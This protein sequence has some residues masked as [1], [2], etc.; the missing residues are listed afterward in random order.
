MLIDDVTVPE[1]DLEI[2]VD[3]IADCEVI[4]LTPST[5]TDNCGGSVIVTNDVFLPINTQGNTIVICGCTTMETEMLPPNSK[6]ETI[7]ID[8][9]VASVSDNCSNLSV[10]DVVISKGDQ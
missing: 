8:Q 10:G 9:C 2:L 4:K 3:M 7:F 6:Y 5:V 1:P